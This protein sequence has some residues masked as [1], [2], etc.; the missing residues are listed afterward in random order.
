MRR[1]ASTSCVDSPRLRAPHRATSRSTTVTPGSS[2]AAGSTSR[3]SARSR[4]NDRPLAAVGER[5]GLDDDADGAGARHDDVGLGDRG[6]KVVDR[7]RA[8]PPT[9]AARRSARASVRLTIGECRRCRGGAARWRRGCS[10]SRR[11]R[12]R[13]ACRSDRPSVAPPGRC[14][15]RRATAR[16]GRCRS[17]CVPACRPAAR[18]RRR[19]RAP[20]R[21]CS[22]RARG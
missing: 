4:T 10:S 22:R 7:Q 19:C 16:P 15:P 14:R 9:C 12:R 17:R 18:C 3:G 21:S 13:R 2:R 11:R 20:G 5:V 6:G 8:R 1:T